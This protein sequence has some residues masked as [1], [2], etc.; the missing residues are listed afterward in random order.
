MHVKEYGPYPNQIKLSKLSTIQVIMEHFY[1]HFHFQ[2]QYNDLKLH[3]V[4]RE[5]S[6]RQKCQR[7]N[8]V[9]L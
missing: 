6:V 7:L 5:T 4:N 1:R 3:F 8:K 9:C 2:K